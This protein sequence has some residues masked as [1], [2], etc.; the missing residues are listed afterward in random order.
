[1][2]ITLPAIPVGVLT[3]LSFF[4]PYLVAIVNHPR[5]EPRYKRLVAIV[6]SILL[7][8][9]VLAVYYVMTGDLVPQWPALLLLAL[10]VQQAAYTLLWRSANAVETTAGTGSGRDPDNHLTP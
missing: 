5:W 3:L 8:L 1:M 2:E 4:A 7:T 9:V 10:V 6:A